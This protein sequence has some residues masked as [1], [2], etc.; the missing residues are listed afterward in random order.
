MTLIA[1]TLNNS[2]PMMIN[3]LLSTSPRKGQN[4][5][6]PT[7][8]DGVEKYLPENI[9]NY[10]VQLTQKSYIIKHNLVVA[11]AGSYIE[12]QKFIVSIKEYYRDKECTNKNIHEF[13]ATIDET[14]LINSGYLILCYEKDSK[15]FLMQPIK[16]GSHGII[17]ENDLLQKIYAIGSGANSFVSEC[18]RYKRFSKTPNIS[19]ENQAMI[20]NFG[21]LSGL[22]ALERFSL[23]T[24]KKYWGAGFELVNFDSKKETFYK[25]DEYTYIIW[26]GKFNTKTSELN[27][28]PFL[29]LSYKY[30]DDILLINSSDGKKFEGTA[31]RPIYKERDEVDLSKLP[32]EFKFH[33]E[34]L[35]NTF[36]IETD[37]GKL[38]TPSIVL[39][40][41]ENSYGHIFLELSPDKGIVVN[42][43]E[44]IQKQ[45]VNEIKNA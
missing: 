43:S 11:I 21:V 26:K 25:L 45:L 13:I 41:P 8:L 4:L 18:D 32:T 44:N 12:N 27:I 29:F 15:G 42:I 19:G 33:D 24:I 30:Y 23:E 16:V 14:E 22:L 38:K 40:K 31:V 36:I 9:G 28:S 37:D 6:L 39:N 2:Y 17:E 35:C 1:C 3:D 7:F 20:L 10:P 34:I 5:K